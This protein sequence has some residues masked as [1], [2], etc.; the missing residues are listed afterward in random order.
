[1]VNAKNKSVKFGI[2]GC[3][4]VAQKYFLPAIDSSNIVELGFIGSRDE[5]K[6]KEW[7]K[8]YG[9]EYFGTYEDVLESNVDA[10]YISLP[11]GLHEE[12]V[13]KAAE[14]GKHIL[15]EKSATTSFDSAKRMV[16]HTKKNNVRLLEAFS[17]RFHPQH[18]LVLDYIHKNELGELFNFYGTYG[19]PAPSLD[20]I[21]WKKELGGGVLNDVTCYPIC[22][23]RITFQSEPISIMSHL[24]YDKTSL[25]DVRNSIFMLYPKNKTAFVSSGFDN[26]YQS[27]YSIWG[28]NGRITTKR[29]YA[30][31]RDYITSIY[32]H[33]D[34]KINEVIIPAVDQFKLM[35]EKFCDVLLGNAALFNFEDDL[36]K[37]AKVLEAVR[38][39]AKTNKLTYLDEIK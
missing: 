28:S 12:W 11:I 29:S 30:V 23:S 34:D 35:I 6:S 9:C 31:P 19:F 36:L 21:R 10:V 24:E 38:Y 33:K 7:A 18:N 4:R 3:S 17:F 32:L 39:S 25:V 22:A 13:L 37:Q 26:Y 14:S 16:E 27:Y 5:K 15:C 1:M 20:N 2:I 8:K